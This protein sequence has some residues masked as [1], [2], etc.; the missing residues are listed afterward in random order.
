M[1]WPVANVFYPTPAEALLSDKDLADLARDFALNE[2]AADE[3]DRI[4]VVL[5]SG[6][7]FE[8]TV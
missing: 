1:R 5:P 8:V 2:C 6:R 3:G 4:D 7:R